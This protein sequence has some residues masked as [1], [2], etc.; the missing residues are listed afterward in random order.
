MHYN[1]R[2][3]FSNQLQLYRQDNN[4]FFNKRFRKSQ[5][6]EDSDTIIIWSKHVPIFLPQM[7]VLLTL[8][9]S[10]YEGYLT[11]DFLKFL[12]QKFRDRVVFLLN[13]NGLLLNILVMSTTVDERVEIN[14]YFAFHIDDLIHYQVL[15]T[16]YDPDIE[17]Y[18][19][20][21]YSENK[22]KYHTNL[23]FF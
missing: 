19:L 8:N 11:H 9:P 5:L 15:T 12:G 1:N 3:N 6:E 13:N 16:E 2:I 22:Y 4:R 10:K 18:Y 20:N 21:D 14:D 23:Q 17:M 7:G